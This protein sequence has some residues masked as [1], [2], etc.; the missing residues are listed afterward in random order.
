MSVNNDLNVNQAVGNIS[1]IYNHFESNGYIFNH[2]I[3]TKLDGPVIVKVDNYLEIFKRVFKRL[4]RFIS[5]GHFYESVSA[6]RFYSNLLDLALYSTE[7]SEYLSDNQLYKLKDSLKSAEKITNKINSNDSIKFRI[8]TL[9]VKVDGKLN[10][11]AL[12]NDY[13]ELRGIL[14]KGEMSNIFFENYINGLGLSVLLYFRERIA[15]EG[16]DSFIVKKA[17]IFDKAIM[18]KLAEKDGYIDQIEKSAKEVINSKNKK[19]GTIDPKDLLTSYCTK[20]NG[21]QTYYNR[22][23][24]LIYENSVSSLPVKSYYLDMTRPG[25][26]HAYISNNEY[27]LFQTSPGFKSYLGSA[28]LMEKQLGKKNLDKWLL[29]VQSFLNQNNFADMQEKILE[30]LKPILIEPK[31]INFNEEL[32]LF[33][34]GNKILSQYP[35]LEETQRLIIIKPEKNKSGIIQRVRF[36]VRFVNKWVYGNANNGFKVI[37]GRKPITQIEEFSLE[38]DSKGKLKIKYQ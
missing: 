15:S 34:K 31:V 16:Q 32:I 5:M 13:D 12:N 8:K 6:K 9:L 11:I 25:M 1:S 30:R 29:P 21:S 36:K 28:K 24:K 22:I 14:N 23:S 38:P 27:V 7:L 18:K 37:E 26:D 10:E 4:I 19:H 2:T 20:I 35:S 17:P 33:K 3:S